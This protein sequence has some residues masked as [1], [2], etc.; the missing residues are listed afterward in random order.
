ME[1]SEKW[2]AF[3]QIVKAQVKEQ[4]KQIETAEQT[5][6]Q[7]DGTAY[8]NAIHNNLADNGAACATSS[9]EKELREWKEAWLAAEQEKY[10]LFLKEEKSR[11]ITEYKLMCRG[12]ERKCEDALFS[13]VE[14]ILVQFRTTDTYKRRMTEWIAEVMALADGQE[15]ELELSPSDEALLPVLTE[16]AGVTPLVSQEEFF[17]GFRCRI[18]ALN[19]YLDESFATKLQ[20]IREECDG[21]Q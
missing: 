16:Q 3:T 15:V 17:G 1:I 14:K 13:Q 7:A 8:D 11:H 10:R 20:R 5:E 4:C 9:Y 21:W 2:K 12:M 19:R 18:V 6:Y